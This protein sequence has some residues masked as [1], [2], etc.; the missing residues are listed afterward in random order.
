M[1]AVLELRDDIDE[2]A[3]QAAWE[4]VVQSTAILRTR[5]VPHNKFGLLQAVVTEDIGW[6]KSENLEEYLQNDK[7]IPMALGDPLT[8]YALVKESPG[9]KFWM[10]WTIHH[11][12]YDGW[13]LRQI[14]HA[15]TKAYT[16]GV[17]EKQIGFHAFI[18][19][20]GQQ[21][22]DS[23]AT[24]WRTTLAN[25]QATL[26]PPLPPTIQQP[27]ANA[28]IIYQCPPL[29]K[30]ASDTTKSIL[31]RAAWAILASRYTNSDDVVFGVTVTGRNAPVTNIET[32][33]GP[34]IATVPLRVR[35]RGDQTVSDFL[36]FLQQQATDMITYEQTG[37]QHIAKMGP[38]ARHA[39]GFQTLLLVQPAEYTF[40]NDKVIGE[41]L[42]HSQFQGF[43]TYVLMLQFTLA[44]EGVQIMA[45]FD[46]RVMEQWVLKKMLGQFSFI[47]QQLAEPNPERELANIDTI[48]TEDRREL[49]A[50]NKNVP[51]TIDRCIHDLFAEQ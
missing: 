27:L 25:C 44:A 12:L 50:W 39:C 49:W 10:V 24:Y 36:K 7:S 30:A 33:A 3:F 22:Q 47:L 20:L 8:R 17:I 31:I 46:A 43:S 38:S 19:Y 42:R 21:D 34:T 18:K 23:T 14:I 11:S 13:S 41:W 4:Y 45:N 28:T 29:P 6:A 37:L 1:H 40:G 5:I 32:M 35:V 16:G 26:F 15:V 48:T 9:G 2:V 51:R